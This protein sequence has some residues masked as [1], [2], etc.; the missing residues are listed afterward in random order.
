MPNKIQRIL[1]YSVLIYLSIP[2]ALFLIGWLKPMY[3]LP[4]TG[5]LIAGIYFYMQKV[6]VGDLTNQQISYWQ[7]FLVIVLSFAW[8]Y[9]SGAG[10][11]SNQDWDYHY[12]NAFL[13]DLAQYKWPVFFDFPNDFDIKFLAGHKTAF[14]YYF[15]YWLPAG[16]IGKWFGQSAANTAL[17]LWNYIG[18]LLVFFQLHKLFNFNYI[19]F[20]SSLFALWSGMDFLGKL[21]IQQHIVGYNEPIEMY[22]FFSYTSFTFDLFDVFNQTIP[23]WLVTL[24]AIQYR[25]IIPVFPLALLIPFAP[26]PFMGLTLYI[27]LVL[28]FDVATKLRE[29]NF[30]STLLYLWE[31]TEKV[32]L[33]ASM[34]AIVLPFIAMYKARTAD[35]YSQFFV[36]RFIGQSVS[37]SV[38]ILVNYL[39]T[40]TLEAGIFF[41]L[42]RWLSPAVYRLNKPTFWVSF[43]LLLF[44]P[45]W[46]VGVW[47]DFASRASIPILTILAVFSL[48]AVINAFVEKR[49]QLAIWAFAVVVLISWIGPFILLSKAP[50]FGQPARLADDIGSL[51]RPKVSA[52]T[53]KNGVLSSLPYYYTLEPQHRFFYRILAK[54]QP[55]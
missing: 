28:A 27:S 47:R 34:I 3:G 51:R 1:D 43:G 19:L 6:P 24:W 9:L 33:A 5:M 7:L 44:I 12:K 20:I 22:Y 50:T 45:V 31:R 2:V 46:E 48:Q 32:S 4:F 30:S 38:T 42:I 41:L 52:E 25:K 29:T 10:G 35:L 53:D 11:F 49:N 17:L 39:L 16:L 13:R 55:H 8:V 37:A 15:T 36:V 14:N 54:P 40:F 26:F 21:L 23:G 18:V